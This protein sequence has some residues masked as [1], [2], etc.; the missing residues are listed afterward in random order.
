MPFC[1]L[2]RHWSCFLFVSLNVC[3]ERF[4]AVAPT[5]VR[6]DLVQRGV[7][8]LGDTEEAE[9]QSQPSNPT[10]AGESFQQASQGNQMHH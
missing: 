6:L 1:L 9:Q 5:E 3:E 7:A 10:A 8:G 2:P 4:N